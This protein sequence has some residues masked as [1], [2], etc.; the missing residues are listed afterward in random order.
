MIK[1]A[2]SFKSQGT[3]KIQLSSQ[4]ADGS[5][6]L[7]YE[8]L[9]T[10][11]Y[12]YKEIQYFAFLDVMYGWKKVIIKFWYWFKFIHAFDVKKYQF[13]LVLVTILYQIQQDWKFLC[14]WDQQ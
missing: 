10:V 7:R 3:E 6:N 4:G 1:V 9:I 2:F 12:K 13:L 11:D 14:I 8:S 5:I